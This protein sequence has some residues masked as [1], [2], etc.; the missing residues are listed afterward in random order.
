MWKQ[1]ISRG[2]WQVPG[3]EASELRLQTVPE[4]YRIPVEE[5]GGNFPQPIWVP[6]GLLSKRR[7]L[8][9]EDIS[10]KARETNF[11]TPRLSTQRQ[12]TARYLIYNSRKYKKVPEV[13]N[14]DCGQ[15]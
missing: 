10:G 13:Y 6:T 5:P 9:P 7:D 11:C 12:R 15:V 4:N 8:Q 1:R 3:I 14:T 2:M